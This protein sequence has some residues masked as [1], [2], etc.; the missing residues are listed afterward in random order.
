MT[1]TDAQWRRREFLVGAW[2]LSES[3]SWP[4]LPDM[5]VGAL[6][7]HASRAQA[8]RLAAVATVGS[9]AGAALHHR[10][11]SHGVKVPLPLTTPRMVDAVDR[12]LGRHPFAGFARQPL[13][14]VPHKVF[15]ARAPAHGVSQG[16]LIVATLLFRGPRL[17][18][19]AM[20]AATVASAAQRHLDRLA[21]SAPALARTATAAASLAAFSLTLARMLRRW[22]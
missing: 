14:G 12:W 13:S 22:E 5:I 18:V 20:G 11:A 8:G 6:S 19:T 15:A 17:A 4:L 3:L 7:A 21:P 16:E 1:L 10:L 2:A 9:A